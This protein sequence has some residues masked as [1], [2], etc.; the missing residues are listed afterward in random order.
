MWKALTDIFPFLCTKERF[1][2]AVF[3]GIRVLLPWW[4]KKM[5]SFCFFLARFQSCSF[6][7]S[8]KSGNLHS[9]FPDSRDLEWEWNL[10]LNH[11]VIQLC[12][13]GVCLDQAPGGE[14]LD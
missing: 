11:K 3:P 8:L 9:T 6:E 1:D 7:N 2:C 5:N 14:R 12:I 13:A 4:V 10:H